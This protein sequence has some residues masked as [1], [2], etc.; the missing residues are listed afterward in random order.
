MRFSITTKL[1]LALGSLFL[2]MILLAGVALTTYSVTQQSSHHIWQ[3]T[4]KQAATGNLRFSLSTLLMSVNDYIITEKESYR[5][6]YGANRI[7]VE[8]RLR[9]LE[10]LPLSEEERQRVDTIRAD[11]GRVNQ[12]ARAIVAIP[13]P[14]RNPEAARLMEEMDYL[15]GDHAFAN[16]AAI[17]DAVAENVM[18]A[19]QAT[20][21]F[22]HQGLVVILLSSA[23]ALVISGGVIVLVL[24]KVSVPLVELA[25]MARRIAARD[26]SAKLVPRSRDE[27]GTLVDAFNTMMGEIQR[28]YDELESFAYV[29]AHDLKTPLAAIH[30]TS[31]ILASDFADTIGEEGRV[32]L[33]SIVASS[34]RMLSLIHDLLEF[35][36]AG[37]V[38]FATGPIPLTKLLEDI[39]S[40]LAYLLDE[41]NVMLIVPPNLPSVEGDPTRLSQVW[42]NLIT[43]AIKYNDK[44]TPVVEVGCTKSGAMHHLFVRDNGIGLRGTDFAR[45]FMPFQRS[46]DDQKY[47]GTGIGLA[48][49]KRVVELHAGRVWLESE[50]G[51]GTTVHLTLPKRVERPDPLPASQQDGPWR[52][53]PVSS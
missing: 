49:V 38:E 32:F 23:L 24:R 29:A 50:L 3:E 8:Q 46:A 40:D 7:E 39:R 28:R 5:H 19:H 15:H 43:N 16:V 31:S 34:E 1:A 33:D 2:V 25:A 41:R 13:A 35:A 21:E 20:H 45:V 51:R 9:E 36:R 26:F 11:V 27:I 52:A 42:R 18:H 12:I 48:I 6:A 4:R 14:R 37:N 10:T 17:Y 22:R 30:G 47:E 44:P 53:T